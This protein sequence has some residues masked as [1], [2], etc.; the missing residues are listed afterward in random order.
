M[1][2]GLQHVQMLPSN[3]DQEMSSLISQYTMKGQTIEH[4]PNSKYLGININSKLNFNAHMDEITNKATNAL[5][6]VQR[7]LHPCDS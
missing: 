5:N 3:P 4:V 1:A 7:T 2:N 6:N